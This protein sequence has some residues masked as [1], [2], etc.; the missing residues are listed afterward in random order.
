MLDD[1]M[2]D[3]S[4]T[5]WFFVF[6]ISVFTF[7]FTFLLLLLSSMQY[8][9]TSIDLGLLYF[10]IYYVADYGLSMSILLSISLRAQELRAQFLHVASFP[11]EYSLDRVRL[12]SHSLYQKATTNH[13]H[14]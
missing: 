13:K 12:T 7:T 11:R 1:L 5:E 6:Q 14:S 9:S 3:V 4:R 8:T 2:L 10:S